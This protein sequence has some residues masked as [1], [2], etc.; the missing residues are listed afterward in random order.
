LIIKKLK[1]KRN[2]KINFQTVADLASVTRATLYNNPEIKIRITSLRDF[3]SGKTGDGQKGIKTEQKR[4]ND[5]IKESDAEVKR[6]KIELDQALIQLI[7]M[8]DLKIE[9]E[10]FRK[11]I[12]VK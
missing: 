1:R 3:H 11:Q 6:L 5:K 8:E 10:R 9:N 4:K 12:R 7:D 2:V